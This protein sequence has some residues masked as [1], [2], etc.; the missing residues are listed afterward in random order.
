MCVCVCVAAVVR[1]HCRAFVSMS[2][3]YVRIVVAATQIR[4]ILF[5]IW[6]EFVLSHFSPLLMTDQFS[7]F[8]LR[9][10]LQAT[11]ST[12]GFTTDFLIELTHFGREAIDCLFSS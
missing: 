4:L 5:F 6:H 7:G 2:K 12:R 8:I 11:L 10:D 1:L 3:T 9:F